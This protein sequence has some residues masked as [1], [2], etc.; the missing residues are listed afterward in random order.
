MTNDQVRMQR[1]KD[2]ADVFIEL[3]RAEKL[4]PQW[5][6]NVFEQL[7]IVGEEYGEAQQAALDMN[8]KGAPIARY[9]EEL[10]QLAAMSLRI[11]FN[12]GDVRNTDSQ[13]VNT[14]EE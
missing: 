1:E 6:K 5:P 10:V 13:S 11:L 12:C 4:H 7:A 3:Q 9:R 14:G 8:Y 2:I